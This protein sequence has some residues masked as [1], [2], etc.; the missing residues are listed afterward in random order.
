MACPSNCQACDSISC[1][2]CVPPYTLSNNTCTLLSTGVS[3]AVDSTGAAYTCDPGCDSCS[4]GDNK[5]LVCNIITAGYS[6]V[7]G[8]IIRCDPSCRTCSNSPTTCLSC[9]PG[10]SLY[11][12][13]CVTCTDTY[14]ISCSTTDSTFS[15]SCKSGYT[16]YLN[17]SA[18]PS[19]SVCTACA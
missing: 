11:G 9:F 1:Y 5:I 6:K 2:Y 7:Q 13:A 19:T 16:A 12:G 17:N 18:T 10:T 15:L 8:K 3:M 14:A 4:I